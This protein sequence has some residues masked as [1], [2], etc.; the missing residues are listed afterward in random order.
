MSASNLILAH[1]LE[2][3]LMALNPLRKQLGSLGLR[4]AE[5]SSAFKPEA[6]LALARFRAR[7]DE[8]QAGVHRG[9]LTP[10]V[11]RRLASEAAAELRRSLSERA[12][13]FSPVPRTFFDRLS[14]ATSV[15]NRARESSSL[16]V[17]QRETN[18]LLRDSLIEQQLRNREDEFRGQT[19]HRR[20]AGGEPSPSLNDLLRFHQSATHAGDDAAR[21]WARRQ[22]EAF[23][24]LTLDPEDQRLIDLACDRP[25][26]LNPRLVSRYVE[27]LDG[28]PT[29]DLDD[30]TQHAIE[31]R[32]ANACVAAYVL[33]RQSPEGTALGWVRRVLDGIDRFPDVAIG[34]LR[35]WEADSRS[36]E[37]DA[38]RAE[39]DLA[40]N[41]AEAEAS[42]PAL[43]APTE[44]E[45][46]R[47]AR[48]ETLPPADPAEPIG[49][50]PRRRGL[51]N[52][53]F[54]AVDAQPAPVD[55]E[56]STS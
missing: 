27:Q 56:D 3:H 7:R 29:D 11:A 17:L 52:E 53:E 40:V 16:E 34:A 13:A 47:R 14:E 23:R 35:C 12:E 37:A 20:V 31:A 22:L 18:R 44:E 24:V 41:I 1:T 21:E 50:V 54:A 19:Y 8:L 30:F 45:L 36:E 42:M 39:V 38:A 6:D 49:L 5:A 55:A 15:R 43:K 10:K 28:V 32:D 46:G 9:E 25:E 4:V 33:A 51:S 26:R 2:R 48:I